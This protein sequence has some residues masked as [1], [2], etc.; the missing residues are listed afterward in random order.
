VDN[1][2]YKHL[3]EMPFV[4]IIIKLL[5]YIL[6]LFIKQITAVSKEKMSWKLFLQYISV[7]I[8]GFGIMMAVFYMNT[9]SADREML[10]VLITLC[11]S[12]FLF[13][14]IFIFY[15]FY[16]YAEKMNQTMEQ[17]VLITKQQAELN[18]YMQALK[19]QEEQAQFLHD[20]VHYLNAV[21]EF[22]GKG[23]CA[24]ILKILGE[25]DQNV[26]KMEVVQYSSHKIINIILSEKKKEAEEQGIFFDVYVEPGIK[27]PK[28]PDTDLIS[29][30]ENLLDNAIRAAKTSQKEPYV[31]VRIFMQDLDGFFVVKIENNFSGTVRKKGEEFMTTKEETGKHGIGIRSVREKA[32]RY[33]GCLSCKAEENVFLAVLLLSTRRMGK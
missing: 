3:S 14:A 16:E 23:D 7:P 13:G 12:L 25:L 29:M 22:A 21:R 24:E 20:T 28:M 27:V 18:Y 5:T 4:V 15:S 9:G 30:L 8:S 33:G 19:N 11:F 17:K 26:E 6:L 2:M 10:K 31:K 1:E 32:E